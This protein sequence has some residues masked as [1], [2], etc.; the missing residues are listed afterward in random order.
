MDLSSVSAHALS[1]PIEP[2]QE[3][4]FHGGRRQL[5]KRDMVLV[6]LESRDGLR[7]VA[8]AGASSSAMREFFE[9]ST[10]KHFADAIEET[11][12]PA[13]LD[14]DLSAPGDGGECVA[15]TDLPEPLRT[16]AASAIDVALYDLFGKRRGAPVHELLAEDR[17]PE[18][19]PLYASAGMYME[20]DGYASQAATLE[21][22]GFE[23]YKYR[24]GI[25]PDA[26]RE[27]I[28]AIDRTTGADFEAMVDAHTWWKL[29]D[30]YTAEERAEV[31]AAYEAHDVYWLEEPVAPDDYD[32]YRDLA[33]TTAVPLAGGESEIDVAGLKT[34][35]DTGAVGFLQ[36]DVRHHGGFTG[37]MDA[38][39]Y[40]QANGV[41][42][43]PHH[44][45][46]TLGLVANAHLVVACGGDLLEYPV[47]ENDPY[48]DAEEDPGMYPN[49]LAFDILAEELSIED[50]TFTVPSGDGLGVSID[51]SVLD[52][53]GFLDGPWTTFEYE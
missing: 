26:D 38:A 9:G 11:V 28:E 14:T 7:G 20:P 2:V 43:V 3:R 39:E 5:H 47:F 46:T 15:N 6:V 36:G 23:G 41:R 22:L 13:L 12:A 4:Q 37:C 45:G 16:Q 35:V 21:S 32:G 29:E 30:P 17:S 51:E 25:G 42:F 10:Q 18:P 34:L 49:Q 27:T 40:A 19:I 1:S 50:G 31:V 44:F 53:Y 8:P 48:L 33:A 24:P 52:S